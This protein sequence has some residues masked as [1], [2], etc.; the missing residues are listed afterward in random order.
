MAT[1]NRG[2]APADPTSV[3]GQVR[4][5]IG[6]LDYE[7]YDP[8]EV[9]FGVYS[10]F[11]DTEIA[12]FI[13]AGGDSVVRASG[14]AYL[15]LAALAAAGAI[16][17]KSD[18]QMLDAKQVATEYRLLAGIAFDQ[19]DNA[20]DGSADTFGLDNPYTTCDNTLCTHQ[21]LAPGAHCAVC[22]GSNY[23][24]C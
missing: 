9:G 13:A 14:Y 3:V 22:G 12:G 24:W 4:F 7:E 18:D 23:G 5:L 21:E 19:A 16:S 8:V 1:V 10:N 11:S 17:W 15:R 2:I 6:D 20:D